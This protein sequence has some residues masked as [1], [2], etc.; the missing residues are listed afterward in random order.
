MRNRVSVLSKSF[1]ISLIL[2]L[3]LFSIDSHAQLSSAG[4]LD[5]VAQRYQSAASG[6]A[7]GL[8]RAA[9]WMFWT[10]AGISLVWTH[11]FLALRKAD[12]A[13]FFAEFLRFT[14]FTGFYWWLLVNGPTMATAII[15]S[16]KQLGTNAGGP[17]LSP[18]GV[19]DIGFDIFFKV[20][21]QSSV[22]S[23]VDSGVGLL[24]G[25]AVLLVLALVGV[26]ML[27]LL[28]TGWFMSFAGIFYLGFGG[29]RWT[30]E[31]SINYY[32]TVLGIGVQL[33]AMILLVGIGKGFIDQYHNGMSGSYTL[34]D[35]SVMLVASVVLFVLVNKVPSQLAGIVGG[36]AV[37][38]PGFGAGSLV[39]AGAT[40]AAAAATGGA[41]M[42]AGAKNIAGGVQALMSAVGKAN[43]NM[44]TGSGMFKGSGMGADGKGG[45]GV[46]STLGGN[47]SD[48][49]PTGGKAS[50]SSS[51]STSTGQRG[52]GGSSGGGSGGA[53][54]GGG[55]SGGGGSTGG[56]SGGGGS[57]GGESGGGGSTGGESGGGESGGGG[58]TG[59]GSTASDSSGGASAGTALAGGSAST[60]AGAS[61]EASQASGGKSQTAGAS[62][63]S[64][65]ASK[66]AAA[67]S[68]AR[69]MASVMGRY[70]ADVSANLAKGAYAVGK[71]RMQATATNL[72][73]EVDKTVGGQIAAKIAGSSTTTAP[74]PEQPAPS[75]GENSLSGS[76]EKS[77]DRD[78]EK[79]AF[80]NRKAS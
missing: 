16:M 58:S 59:G 76:S 29:S 20:V 5:T 32:K 48:A 63:S 6:W 9:S 4:V 19:V 65:A 1:A 55:E 74:A 71:E 8:T 73:N 50:G 28:V 13:E 3:A 52:G 11:G 12:L 35:L 10:L 2:G 34:Q 43:E 42:A 22:W 21:Q 70:A 27:V 40:A 79:A 72:R 30:S 7:T 23:P 80:V 26:N 47:G 25:L 64:A 67:P 18:S 56:E 60:G 33:F 62:S 24:V 17:A 51:G 15:N 57:T 36:G 45:A 54:S 39:A 49:A 41:M 69:Q 53:S 46:A 31:M 37:A 61:S 78:A 38:S 66:Q 75:F 77:V 68:A 44:A 14:I